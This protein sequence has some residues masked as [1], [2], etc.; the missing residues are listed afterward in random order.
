MNSVSVYRSPCEVLKKVN[1]L[2]QGDSELDV[3]VRTLLAESELKSKQLSI[4]LHKYKPN[5]YKRWERNLT[6]NQDDTRRKDK[7]YKY[8]KL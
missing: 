3:K 1:D 4:E 5:F 8:V 6:A 2:F 7:N